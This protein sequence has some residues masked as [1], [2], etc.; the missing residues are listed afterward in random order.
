LDPSY[1]VYSATIRSPVNAQRLSLTAATI[2]SSHML[3]TILALLP[4]VLRLLRSILRS[5]SHLAAENLFLRK[6]LAHSSNL[7]P[8]EATQQ[9]HAYHPRLAVS[10]RRVAEVLTIMRPETPIRCHRD[11][12]RLC[13]RAKLKQ[14]GRPRIPTELQRLIEVPRVCRRAVSVS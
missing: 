14:R 10:R 7:A 2:L 5:H 3:R 12:Y 1:V 11:L 13:W 4:D 8:R 6:Q 9:R